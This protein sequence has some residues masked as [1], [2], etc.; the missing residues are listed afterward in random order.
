MKKTTNNCVKCGSLEEVE[1]MW[2]TETSKLKIAKQGLIRIAMTEDGKMTGSF[3]L[4]KDEVFFYG[5]MEMLRNNAPEIFETAMATIALEMVRED[6][7]SMMTEI[8]STD[9]TAQDY[10]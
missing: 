4:P 10:N 6:L 1:K 8:P 7:L 9:G 2:K 5:I 3:A